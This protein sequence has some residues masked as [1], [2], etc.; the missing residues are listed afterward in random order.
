MRELVETSIEPA[1]GVMFWPWKSFCS[2]AITHALNVSPNVRLVRQKKRKFS[3]DR[4][5]AIKKK[6]EKLIK[7]GFIWKVQYPD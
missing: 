7:I 4:I 2:I 3:P 1:I 5:Q 6:I